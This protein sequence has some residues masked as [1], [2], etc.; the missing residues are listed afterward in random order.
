MS[1]HLPRNWWR[2][3]IPVLLLIAIFGPW[4]YDRISV[5]A[6]Y[7]CNP[8]VR[9]LDGDF[10]GVPMP[11]TFVY[12]ILGARIV[13]I[14]TVPETLNLASMG[15][16]AAAGRIFI[17]FLALIFLIMPFVSTSLLIIKGE[18]KG[19]H[20]LQIVSMGVSSAIVLI[21]GITAYPLH[22]SWAL[23]GL[24]LYIGVAIAAL[25][26]EIFRLVSISR[27]KNELLPA[28]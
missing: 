14:F 11:G 2:I 28:T 21:M 27:T 9:R 26:I 19:L 22:V 16:L 25:V 6:Q 24:W 23:W 3:V 15:T 5:P 1:I 17:V 7:S 13:E 12:I 18:R 20:W 8:P 4:W 10:C